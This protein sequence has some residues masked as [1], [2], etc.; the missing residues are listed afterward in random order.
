MSV[1]IVG[2]GVGGTALAARLA[3]AGLDVTVVEKNAFTG[4]R[5]SLIHR[6]GY[7]R[8]RLPV[9]IFSTHLTIYIALRPRPIFTSDAGILQRDF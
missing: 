9:H 1:I 2:A 6:N 8:F 3:R 5:C 4:G 7:V